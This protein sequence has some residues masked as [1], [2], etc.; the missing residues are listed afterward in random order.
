V[1]AVVATSTATEGSALPPLPLESEQ[2]LDESLI[3]AKSLSR[4]AVK[5]AY[6]NVSGDDFIERVAIYGTNL[7][8]VGPHYRGGKQFYFGDLGIADPALV[9]RLELRDADGDG[10]EDIIIQKRIGAQDA[11]REILQ[12][13]RVPADE[14]PV[15][16]FSHEVAIKTK[17]GLIANQVKI[18]SAGRGIKITI[19]QGDSE[20]FDPDSYA[21]LKQA[22]M[23]S[24]LLPW[25]TI[26][27]RTFQWKATG[28]EKVDEETWSPKKAVTTSKS[29]SVAGSGGARAAASGP[30]A[31]PPPRPPTADELLDRVYALYRKD[32]GVGQRSPRFDF[33]TDVA[34][35]RTPER[36]VVHDRDLVIFGKGFRGGTSYAFITIGVADAKDIL[37]VTSHDLTGDGRAEIIVRALLHATPSEEVGGESVDRYAL[38][39]YSVNGEQLTRIFAAETGRAQGQNR[40][41]GAVAFVPGARGLDIQLRAARGVGWNRKTYPFPQD[42]GSAGGLEPLRLPWASGGAQKYE[43]NGTAYQSR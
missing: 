27:S 43:F 26:K 33:V 20:G 2:G 19:S 36:V 21:E 25:Q 24:A 13:L 11:Y 22:D 38:F 28:F 1:H 35:D 37:D 12:V 41:L 42:N 18:A 14:A 9:T 39:V 17:D 15:A 34:G 40:V 23:P 32:R 8:I 30:P 29:G 5:L 31:P 4:K 10:H 3:R 16:A 7:T 6:G